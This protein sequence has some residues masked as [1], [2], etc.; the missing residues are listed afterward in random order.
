MT[1]RINQKAHEQKPA[2]GQLAP[3]QYF[4]VE[5]R[6]GSV[7][8]SCVFQKTYIWGTQKHLMYKGAHNS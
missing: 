1:A 2:K 4:N 6:Q 8:L 7:F 3:E 5:E